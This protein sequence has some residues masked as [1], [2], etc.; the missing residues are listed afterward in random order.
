MLRVTCLPAGHG[1]CILVEYGDADRP[2]RILLDGGPAHTYAGIRSALERIPRSERH[3]TLMVVT[4][5]DADHIDG[6]LILLQDEALGLTAE[7]IWFNG[8]PQL[9]DPQ[10]PDTLGPAQGA[11]LEALLHERPW[12][13]EF[14][15]A[16]IVVPD[17][18]ALPVVKLAGGARITLLSPRPKALRALR[19]TWRKVLKEAGM[20]PGDWEEARQRLAERRAYAPPQPRDD[21]FA[22]R[23]FGSDKAVANG[24]SIAFVLSVGEHRVLLGADAHAPV[25]ADGLRR[26]AAAEGEQRL[27]LDAIKLS[28]HGSLANI[29][30]ELL[31][32]V[33]CS[34]FLVSTNGDYFKHPDPEAIRLLGSGSPAPT[35]RFNHRSPTTAPW[36]DAGR[37]K[38]D[39]IV[40]VFPPDG[41][42]LAL[43]TAEIDP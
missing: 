6:A 24:S 43:G 26:M 29:S 25:L 28:H 35:V 10:A 27:R 23:E 34:C 4:H 41:A 9:K 3:L 22:G 40:A 20:R 21:V 7:D 8:W 14:G 42:T 12:N 5:V 30:Q 33:E 11:F 31:D 39:G 19:A 1:D 37:C 13:R 18:G 15:G 16:G 2:S 32:A 38:Q 17:D 36:S